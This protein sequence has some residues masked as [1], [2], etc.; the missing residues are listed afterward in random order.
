ML[1]NDRS[2]V[3]V[4]RY[5]LNFPDFI[6]W[7]Q[8]QGK[9][10]GIVLHKQPSFCTCAKEASCARPLLT[11]FDSQQFTDQYWSIAWR[12][13]TPVLNYNKEETGFNF[14]GLCHPAGNLD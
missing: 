13:V 8:W 4:F 1:Y 14:M 10:G 11:Q 7:Q 5:L 3:S 2:K 6:E 9:G 12:L